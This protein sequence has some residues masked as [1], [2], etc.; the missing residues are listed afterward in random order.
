MLNVFIVIRQ[1]LLRLIIID[2]LKEYSKVW[3]RVSSLMKI[4]FDS[5]PVYGNNDK[6]IKA[7]KKKSYEDKVNINFLGKKGPK[8]NASYKCLSLI[9]LDS[10]AGVSKNYHPQILLE[11]CEYMIKKSKV[12]NLVNDDLDSSS[13]DNE[14]DNEFDNDQSND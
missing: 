14:S 2:H 13:S 10:V 12:E 7:K 11:E 8:E 3:D 6:Y 5:E 9:I 4:E 1:C